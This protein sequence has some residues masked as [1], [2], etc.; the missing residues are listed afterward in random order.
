[1]DTIQDNRY[2]K[3]KFTEWLNKLKKIKNIEIVIAVVVLALILIIYAGAS[4]AKKNDTKDDKYISSDDPV[5]TRL[6]E[7]LSKIDGAGSVDVMIT[8]K[9]SVEYVT[10]NTSNVNTNTSTDTNRTNT[11]TSTTTS[12]VIVN[13]NGSSGPVIIKEIHPDVKGVIV[14]ADGAENIR[15]RLELMRAVM[16]ALDIGS[17]NIEIFSKQ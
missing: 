14:V 9:G 1:M 6:E 11:T 3:A 12:P 17:Q 13:N 8:Y 5:E 2:R 4:A 10:A 15:V 16:V 7:I